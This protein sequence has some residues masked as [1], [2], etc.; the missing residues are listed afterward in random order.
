MRRVQQI[1]FATVLALGADCMGGSDPTGACCVGTSCSIVTEAECGGDYLGDATSCSFDTCSGAVCAPPTSIPQTPGFGGSAHGQA[2]AFEE[3]TIAVGDSSANGF[4]GAVHLSTAQGGVWSSLVTIPGGAAG[5]QFGADVSMSGNWLAS[6]AVGGGPGL[7]DLYERGASG[8]A[9]RGRVEPPLQHVFTISSQSVAIDGAWLAVAMVVPF[10]G[11]AVVGMYHYHAGVWTYVQRINYGLASDISLDMD[12]G[13]LVVGLPTVVVQG[14]DQS[15]YVKIYEFS[16][17]FQTWLELE[18]FQPTGGTSLT[19]SGRIVSTQN[20]RVAY[21]IGGVYDTN[22][23]W[24]F[25]TMEI[26]D[27]IGETWQVVGSVSFVSTPTQL[28]DIDIRYDE[29]GVSSWVPSTGAT[30]TRIYGLASLPSIELI[31]FIADGVGHSQVELYDNMVLFDL[32]N[33]YSYREARVVPVYDCDDN[34]RS[35][36]CDL[37]YPGADLN[38]DGMLDRCECLGNINSQVDSVVDSGDVLV[39]MSFYWGLTNGYGDC[40]GDDVCNVYDLLIILNQ[41]GPCPE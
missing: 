34:F 26:M 8:W 12:D 16:D 19:R 29:I 30:S 25:P 40:N 15:G 35:D 27:R 28:Q 33:V 14:S 4:A 24:P 13:L 32:T 11:E 20:G 23:A 2:L 1:G 17:T 7:I 39:L 6:A 10:T 9:W 38:G 3:N 18:T 22:G 37:E 41:W 31:D 36:V 5:E 21:T